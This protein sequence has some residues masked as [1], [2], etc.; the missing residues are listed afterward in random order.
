MLGHVP[1]GPFR[2]R[3]AGATQE[4]VR[5][6]RRL[7]ILATCLVPGAALDE[8]PVEGEL[9]LALELELDRAS[10]SVVC[11]HGDAL[12][13]D[14]PRPPRSPSRS[15]EWEAAWSQ[16]GSE[17]TYERLRL[18]HEGRA[19]DGSS[20]RSSVASALEGMQRDD[21]AKDD[22]FSWILPGDDV[23]EPG[24]TWKLHADDLVHALWLH[25]LGSIG[26]TGHGADDP[27]PMIHVAPWPGLPADALR[28][29]SSIEGA[30]T[31]ELTELRADEAGPVAVVALRFEVVATNA[32]EA[33]IARAFAGDEDARS[34][35][36]AF[37]YGGDGL[38]WTLSGEAEVQWSVTSRR[39]LAIDLG[40]DVEVRC[41]LIWTYGWDTPQVEQ[42]RGERSEAWT[43]RLE[44]AGRCRAPE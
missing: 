10:T 44:L 32:P 36:E 35:A 18:R 16:R 5:T 7:A 33:W 34:L 27:W 42:L 37:Q 43:G 6:V 4:L 3:W 24:A 30:V 26:Y 17:R 39:V 11:E 19:M 12:D 9:R 20:W 13:L 1:A 15:L 14:L 22:S 25:D 31:G 29:P 23:P 38:E 40:A 2:E 21:E 41:R 28:W 8:A